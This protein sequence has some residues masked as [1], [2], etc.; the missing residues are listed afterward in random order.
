MSSINIYVTEAK[1]QQQ[2]PG[3]SESNWL[4]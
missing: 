1:C 4:P 3:D 2:Q